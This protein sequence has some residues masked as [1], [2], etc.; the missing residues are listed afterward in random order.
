MRRKPN[1]PL[2]IIGLLCFWAWLTGDFSAGA[3][4]LL[5]TLWIFLFVLS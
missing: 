1:H 4:T 2:F 3:R 5:F